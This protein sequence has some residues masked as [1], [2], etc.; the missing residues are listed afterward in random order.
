MYPLLV[1]NLHKG[2][3]AN[4]REERDM[5]T[6][7]IEDQLQNIPEE[8]RVVVLMQ[9]QPSREG[10]FWCD[11][12]WQAVGVMVHSDAFDHAQSP[13]LVRDENGIRQFLYSG[14][15]IRL[16]TD[17]CEGYYYN[18]L[19]PAPCCYVIARCDDDGDPVPFM[20]TLNLDDAHAYMETEEQVFTVSMPPELYRWVE[21]FVLL[22]YAP[23][24]RQKRKRDDWKSQN[25]A[26]PLEK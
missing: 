14:F 6:K 11:Y 12:Q 23:Q 8:F 20:V 18:L 25:A 22:H 26:G 10:N 16:Y 3:T 9:Q 19:S 7:S 13:Q 1:Y 2:I 21:D 15:K 24:K 17:E 5:R 4:V